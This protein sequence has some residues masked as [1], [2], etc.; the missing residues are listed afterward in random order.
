MQKPHTEIE[1][2]SKDIVILDYL[3]TCRQLIE[4]IKDGENYERFAKK[5]RI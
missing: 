5:S 4:M 1:S 2:L 3:M